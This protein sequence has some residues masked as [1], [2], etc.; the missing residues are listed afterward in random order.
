MNDSEAR[1][2]IVEAI[3]KSS[4]RWRTPN[5]IS[6]DSGVPS[7]QVLDILD[8]SDAFVRS[9]KGNATGAA[10]FTTTEKYKSGTPLSQRILSALTN[11][12]NE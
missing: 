6:R 8:N 1:A 12:I 10:L 3:N 7:S 4:Y 2:L 11:K 5:G 9:R